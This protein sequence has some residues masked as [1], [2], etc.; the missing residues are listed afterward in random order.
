MRKSKFTLAQRTGIVEEH[1]K[2]KTVEQICRDHQISAATFYKWQDEKQ[3]EAEDS[4]RR[5]EQLEKEN[6]R[7][8]KMYS[9]LS[10]DHEI[11]KEGYEVLKKIRAQDNKKH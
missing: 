3:T 4:R 8:K 9:E 5:L 11:L 7:L 6:K 10:I 1:T 2:G